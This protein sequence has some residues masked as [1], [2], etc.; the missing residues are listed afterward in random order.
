MQPDR[1]SPQSLLVADGPV[2]DGRAQRLPGRYIELVVDAGIHARKSG[3]G[4]QTREL[5][6]AGR[7]KMLEHARGR[8]RDA[9]MTGWIGRVIGHREQCGQRL[10]LVRTDVEIEILRLK[11]AK[12]GVELRSLR[13]CEDLRR[14]A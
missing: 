13:E 2:G 11:T 5:G 3:I 6:G 4:Y 7:E 14:R 1:M 9:G 10:R 12:L 8:G